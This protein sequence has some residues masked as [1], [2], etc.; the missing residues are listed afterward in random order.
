MAS[1]SLKKTETTERETRKARSPEAIGWA[2]PLG[3]KSFGKS[4]FHSRWRQP[5]KPKL[6]G[7]NF[8]L[9]AE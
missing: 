8:T 3:K 5:S 6:V 2:P 9:G 1:E 7:C 4:V